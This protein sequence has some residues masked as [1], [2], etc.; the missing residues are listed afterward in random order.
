MCIKFTF[1]VQVNRKIKLALSLTTKSIYNNLSIINLSIII[2]K[3]SNIFSIKEFQFPNYRFDEHFPSQRKIERHKRYD[4]TNLWKIK[5]VLN[6]H[7]ET[8]ENSE[9]DNWFPRIVDGSFD[10]I[11]QS[12]RNCRFLAY[13]LKR[14]ETT[15]LEFCRPREKRQRKE[16][17][18]ETESKRERKGERLLSATKRYARPTHDTG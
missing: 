6:N 10:E 3:L 18:K 8:R 12:D 7:R 5:F 9:H 4:I 15:K 11:F 13:S 16:R 14:S 17:E 2:Y 1:F